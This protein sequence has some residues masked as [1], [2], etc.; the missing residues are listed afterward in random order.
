MYNHSNIAWLRKAAE[1]GQPEAQFNFG[2]I[3]AN[4]QGVPRDTFK[5]YFWLL[6]AREQQPS[7]ASHVFSD[8][9]RHLSPQQC[10][11]AH[12]DVRSWRASAA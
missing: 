6:L 10:A 8:V 11:I 5:A 3:H 7:L 1:Q 12:N 9:E 4:G 2:L